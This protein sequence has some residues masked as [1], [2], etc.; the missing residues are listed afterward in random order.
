MKTR[1]VAATA[2]MIAAAASAA[3]GAGLTEQLQADRMTVLKVDRAGGRVQCAEHQKWTAVSKQS[4]EAVAPGDI[5]RMERSA[6]TATRLVVLR[7]AA[8]EMASP[9]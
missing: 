1:I 3:L 7:T 9:E 8:D 5:V 4:L 6:G 2:V